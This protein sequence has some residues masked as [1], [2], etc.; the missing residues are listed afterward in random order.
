[1]A[2]QKHVVCV[3]KR[4]EL[5]PHVRNRVQSE[6]GCN[7]TQ[8]SPSGAIFNFS[9]LPAL[10]R[11]RL[12]QEAKAHYCC[13]TKAKP[14]HRVGSSSTTAA[15]GRAMQHRAAAAAKRA[16]VW[17]QPTPYENPAA[18]LTRTARPRIHST[19]GQL[20]WRWLPATRYPAGGTSGAGPAGGGTATRAGGQGRCH[21]RGAP[22]S[23]AP[24]PQPASAGTAVCRQHRTSIVPPGGG[25]PAPPPVD[26]AGPSPSKQQRRDGGSSA[27]PAGASRDS[28]ETPHLVGPAGSARCPAE[29]RA[30]LVGGPG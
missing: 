24:R 12:Q 14:A 22:A 20:G 21:P 29:D 3:G 18:L 7:W 11:K 19:A 25:G 28:A 1:M 10:R 6:S 13:C 2:E 4:L 9:F 8:L 27:R 16:D 30:R 15:Q 17:R 5:N 26:A 23:A